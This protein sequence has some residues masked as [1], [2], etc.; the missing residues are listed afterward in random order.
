MLAA[1]RVITVDPTGSIARIIRVVADLLDRS[2]TVIDIASGQE[3]LAEARTNDCAVLVTAVELEDAIRGYQL[4]IEVSQASPDTRAIVLAE[5]SDPEL[6]LDE[7][8]DSPYV[9]M[10]RPVDLGLFARVMVAALD[11]GD[12]FAAAQNPSHT[13]LPVVVDL[14]KMPFLDVEVA[15]PIIDTLLTDVG[16]MAIVFANRTGEVLLERGAVG[17]LDREKLTHALQPMFGT[18]IEMGDLV[19]GNT[20][21]L[22]FYDGDDYDVFVISVGLHHFLCLV[23]N[24]E[25]GNRAFGSVN[26]FGR[27]A[28][29]D[30]V[31]LLG[32]PAFA[33]E[34]TPKPDAAPARKPRRH[35]SEEDDLEDL[36]QPLER[37]ETSYETYEEPELMQ[38][39][40]IQELDL[41][42][43]DHLGEL[44]L[45]E[46]DDLFSPERLAD[47]ANEGARKGELIDDDLARQLGIMPKMD[48]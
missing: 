13:A 25:A 6:D 23:F 3:A 48:E 41:S 22:H 27:R 17:Y 24:G 7:L 44:D 5:S 2:I 1:P 38:L 33:V 29:E 36:F 15:R 46:A 26:R 31:A 47:L 18:T 16:A 40:P 35:K 30:L 12:I 14:G 43:F 42:I 21:T 32:S 37:A 45:D 11:G 20:R 8:A 10:H 19:G 39:E 4:A 34:T 28:A 9:Y